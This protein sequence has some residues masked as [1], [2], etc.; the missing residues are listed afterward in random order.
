MI[1]VQFKEDPNKH[2]VSMEIS[3][4]AMAGDYGEDVVCA[5]VSALSLA[6]VNNLERMAD[7]Q[8]LVESDPKAGYL[9]V[10]VPRELTADQR[11]L[12]DILFKQCQLAL[13][14]DIAS[15]YP[16]NVQYVQG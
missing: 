16:D 1:K 10:E 8:A 7:V 13:K 4:H 2:F 14:E 11:Q 5:G 9:Y 3:G 15:N 6:L 12:V